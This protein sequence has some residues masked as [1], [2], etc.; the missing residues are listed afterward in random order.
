MST[1]KTDN[2][3]NN[4]VKPA[5]VVNKYSNIDIIEICLVKH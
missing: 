5:S 2:P 1:P 3:I 4:K